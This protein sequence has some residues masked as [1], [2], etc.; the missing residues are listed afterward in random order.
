M[1]IPV[2]HGEGFFEQEAEKMSAEKKKRG[3]AGHEGGRPQLSIGG[4]IIHD[5][6]ADVNRP[7]EHRRQTCLQADQDHIR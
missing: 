6:G 1:V 7:P 3:S 2:Y 5:S 4:R